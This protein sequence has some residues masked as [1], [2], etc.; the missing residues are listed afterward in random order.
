MD[1]DVGKLALK[2]IRLVLGESY[3]AILTIM[4]RP[5]FRGWP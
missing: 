4:R 2:E 3:P 1:G 5:R